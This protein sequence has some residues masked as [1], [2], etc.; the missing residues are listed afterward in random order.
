M[1]FL[2]VDNYRLSSR[3]GREN[4]NA[5]FLSRLP[6][7]PTVEDI[8]GSS[9]LTDPD[10][11]GVYLIRACGYIMPSCPNPG[12]GLRGLAS[13]P[14]SIIGTGSNGFCPL[15]TP[16]LGGVPLTKDDFRTHR[17][18][19]PILHMTGHTTRFFAAPTEEPCSPYAIHDQHDTSQSKCARRTQSQAVILAGNTPVRPDYCMAAR[20]GFTS[21]AAPAPSSKA[22]FRSSP[23]PRLVRL[24]STILLGRHAS[25]RPPSAPNLELDH[26]PPVAPPVLQTNAGPD[27]DASAAA[28]HLSNTLLSYSHRDWEQA[29]RVDPLCDATG[30]YIQLGCPNLP[31]PTLF[32][33]TCHRTRGLKPQTSPNLRQKVVYCGEM[34]T[35]SYSS[36]NL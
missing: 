31:S 17:P 22:R 15:P 34:M 6:P 2:S 29:Q 9:A 14:N 35:L 18:S 33:T 19:T 16:V 10:D 23:P 24:G 1:E 11:L 7:P 36:G 12:V 3:R 4:A 32:A 13:T 30:R 26:S 27:N 20:S 21:S 5:N 28:E 25:P 8:S